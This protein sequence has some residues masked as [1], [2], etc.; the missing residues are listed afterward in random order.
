MSISNQAPNSFGPKK[1][2][3]ESTKNYFVKASGG[4]IMICGNQKTM[5]YHGGTTRPRLTLLFLLAYLKPKKRCDVP[6][7]HPLIA[8]RYKT[9]HKCSSKW[10]RKMC[11][12]T[13]DFR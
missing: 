1:S 11:L 12:N 2:L 5:V 10:L 3:Q 7:I 4:K 9:L 13:A 8:Q 6:T